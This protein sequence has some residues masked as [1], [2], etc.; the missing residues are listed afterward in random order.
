MSDIFAILKERVL[1]KL[2]VGRR[3]TDV[4]R[5]WVPGCATGED[6]YSLA[7]VLTEFMSA[8]GERFPIQIFGTDL[9][10]PALT[11]ARSGKYS[12][13]M[14]AN[15]APG[16]MQEFFQR[17]DGQYQIGEAIREICVFARQNVVKPPPV[18]R[19]DLIGGRNALIYLDPALRSTVLRLFHYRLRRNGYLIADD[20]EI[21]GPTANLF[22]SIDERNG[23][24]VRRP[25]PWMPGET[26]AELVSLFEKTAFP[27]RTEEPSTR[28]ELQG[29][30]KAPLTAQENVLSQ[31][32]ELNTVNKEWKSGNSELN[33]TN[34]DLMNVLSGVSLPI[35]MVDKDL[36][37]RWFTHQA[38]KMLSH[39]DAAGRPLIDLRLKIEAPDL[40]DRLRNSIETLSTSELDVSDADG[41]WYSMV[42]RPYRTTDNRIDGSV[43]TF[44]DVTERKREAEARYRTVF[45]AATDGILIADATSGEI[46][47]VNPFL[48]R[49]LDCRPEDLIGHRLSN[50]EPFRGA[51]MDASWLSELNQQPIVQR[52]TILKATTGKD[53]VVELTGNCFVT[54]NRKQIRLLIRDITNRKQFEEKLRRSEEQ[55]RQAEKVEAIGQLA[56]GIAHDFNN[57]ITAI[58]AQCHVLQIQRDLSDSLVSEVDQVITLAERAGALTQQLLAFSRKQTLEPKLINMNRVLRDLKPMIDAVVKENVKFEIAPESALGT[59]RA[60]RGQIEQ[61]VL[62][63]A[64]NARD[65]MPGGGTFKAEV[66]E[67]EV[68]DGSGEVRASIPP[69]RY[70]RLT[71]AD[72]GIGMTP[73]VQAHL[74]EAF[75][76]TKPRGIGTGLGLSSTYGIVRQSG[77]HILVQSELGRGTAF[78]IYFPWVNETADEERPAR[79]E[80]SSEDRS[81]LLLLVEDEEFLRS[82]LVRGLKRSGYRVLEAASGPQ[83]LEV[84]E[85]HEGPIDLVVTDILMPGMSGMDLAKQLRVKRQG[86]KVL[87]M[88]GHIQNE[89]VLQGVRDEGLVLL[90]KPFTIQKLLST[91]SQIL[92]TEDHSGERQRSGEYTGSLP[93][94]A[95]RSAV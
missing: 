76:T 60:D 24:Y 56:S 19:L 23:I 72:T 15:I 52:E 38:E 64:I 35:I 8:T 3:A 36:R 5:V 43:I 47:E 11:Q 1:P 68:N 45:A 81:A 41:N 59:I 21:M 61:V 31:N 80:A 13:E 42:I 82:P 32:G 67:A 71:L 86:L 49:L 48:Q 18:R 89:I 83:A 46:I 95:K 10:E 53:V 26:S 7:I 93:L 55:M 91:I 6:V 17:L 25:R 2:L 20:F 75:F 88:S 73:E 9:S 51:G 62:N 27:G 29:A 14:A 65:A 39:P 54:G 30:G 12:E 4:I 58:I 94:L 78:K 40:H 22:E 92:K 50:A 90:N 77:A 34:N 66:V 70:V 85:S 57:L 84:A 69:G 16:R 74:F 37:I 28:E 33:Q 79:L 63:L 87:F 44:F